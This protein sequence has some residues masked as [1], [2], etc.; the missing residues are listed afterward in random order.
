MKFLR[1]SFTLVFFS[2]MS[3]NVTSTSAQSSVLADKVSKEASPS[4]EG[5]E[6]ASATSENEQ[7]KDGP[8]FGLR[9]LIDSESISNTWLRGLNDSL[10]ALGVPSNQFGDVVASVALLVVLAI[11]WF[12]LKKVM[13][14]L[15]R[16]FE[17]LE[18]V[19]I[20]F[21]KRSSIYISFLKFSITIFLACLAL[22][23]LLNLW[24]TDP[25]NSSVYHGIYQF[26]G[27]YA[28]LVF[29]MTLA[30]VVYEIVQ[31]MVEHLFNRWES[32]GSAR[33]HT[34]LPLARNFVNI[35]LFVVFGIMIISELGINVMPLLA[36][37]GVI[38][39]AIG[40]GAQTLVKDLITGF[41]IV[42]E[43]LVQV[44]DVVT[45][46]DR[47]GLIE[48]ITIRKIQLRGLDG[49]V[50]TVPFSEI[51]VVA[52]MTKE[53][54]YYLMDIGIAYRED[55]DEVIPLLKAISAELEEDE[56]YK[57]DILEP[58]EI[59]GVDQFADSAVIIKARI[60]TK[61]IKQWSIGREFNRR[62]KQR[63]D[64]EGIEIPFPHQTIYFGEAKDGTATSTN[65]SLVD[66]RAQD[67]ESND[68]TQ[69]KQPTKKS[70]K[71]DSETKNSKTKKVENTDTIADGDSGED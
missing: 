40:F 59:L 25:E 4:E 3:F 56:K 55:T 69:S 50:Y 18:Y 54:S 58:I 35:T 61:P 8:D 41:I 20:S 34:I 48:R 31:T 17:S 1:F 70:S 10:E 11:F 22:I 51:S 16:K 28:T 57:D 15:L 52:N 23:G 29:L 42:L 27:F 44:G 37:A 62:M 14:L 71:P 5:S 53:Y 21:R 45:V 65:V 36:G 47:S 60:K 9:E 32:N 38:G 7:D 24:V 43:D 46:G 68:E 2:V 13:M 33:M 26:F 12:I 66:K 39:F 19:G 67:S 64:R 30:A 49:V 6:E 63:F